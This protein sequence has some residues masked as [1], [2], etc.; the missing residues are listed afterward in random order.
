MLGMV[1][2]GTQESVNPMPD[3]DGNRVDVR[4]TQF[5]LGQINR[6]LLFGHQEQFLYFTQPYCRR[7]L[8]IWS[9]DD[10]FQ[11]IWLFLL[12]IFVN[13]SQFL[14]F[15]VL[16]ASYFLMHLW[17]LCHLGLMPQFQPTKVMSLNRQTKRRY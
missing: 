16:L 6:E 7:L 11:P 8:M 15:R 10:L 4:P 2:D 17:L 13:F 12:C 14:Y 5:W 1:V 3:F 9:F